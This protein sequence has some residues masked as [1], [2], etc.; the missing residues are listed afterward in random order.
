VI[1]SGRQLVLAGLIALAASTSVARSEPLPP[2][3]PPPADLSTIPWFREGQTVWID[4][5][6]GRLKTR[7]YQ[8]AR[9][10]ERPLLVVL[11]HGDLP[12]PWQGLYEFA[13]AITHVADNVVAA[14]VLRPGYKDVQGDSSSGKMGYAIGDNYTP[15]VVDDVDAAIRQL[16]AKYHAGRVLVIGHS[17]GGAISANLIGRHPEDVDA[18][19]LLACGCDPREF[20]TRFV[21]EHPRF[22]K[23]LPNPSLLPIELAPNVPPRMHVRMVT[24]DKDDV[25]LLPA[26]RAYAQALASHGVDVKLAIAPGAGHNDIFRT[27]ETRAALTELLTLE[28]AKML[29]PSAP[30]PGPPTIPWS[31]QP[32]RS[33]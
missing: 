18:A 27:P 24:G 22:P 17:G 26:S 32:K 1:R 5:P 12:N 7:V 11:V 13:Q 20:M 23:N 15:E 3:P 6:A 8:S 33:P 29:P 25:V 14:G 4:I 2:L 30:Q 31:S 28:G 19:L 10:S 21:R 16:K 9:L